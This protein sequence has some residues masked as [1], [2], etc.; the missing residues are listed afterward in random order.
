MKRS[1]VGCCGGIAVAIPFSPGCQNLNIL[2]HFLSRHITFF[3]SGRYRPCRHENSPMFSNTRI[4][5]DGG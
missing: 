5:D 2:G 3:Q 4:G 1:G